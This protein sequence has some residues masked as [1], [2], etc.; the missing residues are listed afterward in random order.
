ML[1]D[2]CCRDILDLHDIQKEIVNMVQDQGETTDRIGRSRSLSL[3]L[4]LSLLACLNKLPSLFLHTSL[5]E[6]QVSH[7]ANRVEKGQKRLA[8]VS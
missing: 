8:E 4:S 2:V 6:V 5:T 1:D 7:A 3:S